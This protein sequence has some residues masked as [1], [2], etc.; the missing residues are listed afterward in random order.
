MP[1]ISQRRILNDYVNRQAKLNPQG[2]SSAM[3]LLLD[4]AKGAASVSLGALAAIFSCLFA[5][6]AY[7][8]SGPVAGIAVLIISMIL[9]IGLA[10]W[11]MAEMFADRD[12]P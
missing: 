7:G 11:N 1:T 8:Y 2:N 9:M 6:I 4:Y 3:Q 10:L 12:E 5:G